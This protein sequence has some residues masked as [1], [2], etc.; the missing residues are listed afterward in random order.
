MACVRLCSNIGLLLLPR[1]SIF[2]PSFLKHDDDVQ[3]S[4]LLLRF[5]KASE[6]I[7]TCSKFTLGLVLRASE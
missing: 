3:L 7:E 1:R 6:R 4:G 2:Q 5:V